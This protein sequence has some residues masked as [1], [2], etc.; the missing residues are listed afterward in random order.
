LKGDFVNESMGIKVFDFAWHIKPFSRYIYPC[1]FV[2]KR[3]NLAQFGSDSIDFY[4]QF[5]FDDVFQTLD[6]LIVF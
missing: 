2:P 5:H 1:I 3:L 4:A 6:Q